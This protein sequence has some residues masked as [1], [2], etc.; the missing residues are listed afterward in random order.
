MVAT[1][2]TKK[3]KSAL[4]IY[5]SALVWVVCL[6][7]MGLFGINR[8][9]MIP[10]VI[11]IMITGASYMI[12]SRLVPDREV[13]IE[14]ILSM[15]DQIADD[16]YKE[17]NKFIVQ[18]KQLDEKIE[19]ETV[20]KQIQRVAASTSEL[21]DFVVDN[22]QQASRLRK[23]M[24]YYLPTLTSLLQSY[25]DLEEKTTKGENMNTAMSEIEGIMHTVADA[26]E[27]QLDLLY[28]DKKVDIVSDIQVLETLMSQQGLTKEQ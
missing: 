27:K 26:F 24:T 1:K 11:L 25:G 5:I 17:G 4:P 6:L 18:L 10:I 22:P 13:E 28:M 20:S 21:L 23:F 12:A 9:S 7:L 2:K 8:L 14:R 19:D 16:F 15:D 3:V